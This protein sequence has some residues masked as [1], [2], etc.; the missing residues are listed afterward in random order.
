MFRNRPLQ[1]KIGGKAA[2]Q[3]PLWLS[4]THITGNLCTMYNLLFFYEIFLKTYS[5]NSASV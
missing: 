1:N 3:L 5:A 2:K 4:Q